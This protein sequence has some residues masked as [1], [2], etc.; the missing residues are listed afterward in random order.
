MRVVGSQRSVG[1]DELWAVS[2]PGV[3]KA[4]SAASQETT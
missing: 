3:P 1:H 4:T 2:G